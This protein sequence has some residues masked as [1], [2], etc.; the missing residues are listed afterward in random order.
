MFFCFYFS[1]IFR[2]HILNSWRINF[3]FCSALFLYA[4]SHISHFAFY[5]LLS[6][7]IIISNEQIFFPFPCNFNWQL[8]LN[9]FVKLWMEF[10]PHLDF[11]MKWITIHTHQ[12]YFEPKTRNQQ[13]MTDVGKNDFHANWFDIFRFRA[14]VFLWFYTD[15]FLTTVFIEIK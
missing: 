6:Y 4:I 12:I 15:H 10:V 8:H 5:L 14:V 7:N 1:N 9:A 2:I 3:C 11:W 13:K